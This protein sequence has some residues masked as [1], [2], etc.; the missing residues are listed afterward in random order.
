MI[1][2]QVRNLLFFLSDHLVFLSDGFILRYNDLVSMIDLSFGQ[3]VCVNNV[4]HD[5]LILIERH[6]FL[7]VLFGFF[8][9]GV[10]LIFSLVLQQVELIHEIGVDLLFSSLESFFNCSS[11]KVL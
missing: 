3:D 5:L 9:K 1:F 4:T 6:F 8:A 7:F 10:L 11:F 2:L